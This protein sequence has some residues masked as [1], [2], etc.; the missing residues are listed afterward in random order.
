MTECALQSSTACLPITALASIQVDRKVLLFAGQGQYLQIYDVNSTQISSTPIF[1]A[2]PV[3]GIRVLTPEACRNSRYFLLIAIWGGRS[4]RIVRIKLEGYIADFRHQLSSPELS[5]QQT[6]PDWILDTAYNDNSVFVLTAHNQLQKFPIFFG[7]TEHV[8]EG[9]SISVINGPKSFLYSGCLTIAGPDLMIVAS[10]TVFGEIL[11]W[12]CQR[13]EGEE[14]WKPSPSH[15]FM[16]HKGSVF[17]VSI[18]DVLDLAGIRKRLLASCSDDRTI[19]LWDISDCDQDERETSHAINSIETGFGAISEAGQAHIACVWGHASRIW[20]VEFVPQGMR[21]RDQPVSLLSRGED[22]ACQLWDIDLPV[23]KDADNGI[24]VSIKPKAS[25]RIH[26]GKN[27]WSMCTLKDEQGMLVHTGGADGQMISRRFE[28]P[29]VTNRRPLTIVVPFNKITESSKSLK[30]YTLLSQSEC[31]ATTDQGN[32]YRLSLIEGKLDWEKVH[33]DLPN[34]GVTISWLEDLSLTLL[35]HQKGGLFALMDSQ[36]SL[37][38]VSCNLNDP[39]SWMQAAGKHSAGS[40]SPRICVVAVSS[41]KEAVIL[42]MNTVEDSVQARQ[43]ALRLPDTFTITAC[44][45]DQSSGVLLL[46]SRAGALAIYS[47]F[48]PELS[49]AQ[50]AYCVRH[51]HATDS[52][53][54]I[55][56]LP[57]EFG[58][59]NDTGSI[60]VLTTGRDGSYAIHRLKWS[61]PD[62]NEPLVSVVHLSSPPFGPNVEGAYLVSSSSNEDHLDLILYGFRS[63]CFIVWNETQQFEVVSVEC[64]GAHRSWCYKDSYEPSADNRSKSFIWTKAGQFN[65]HNSNGSSHKV[66]RGGG[67][68]REI[69]AVARSSIP[70]TGTDGRR[71]GRVLV[72]T[73][74][75][76]TN[77]LLFAIPTKKE[78]AN[79]DRSSGLQPCKD[80]EFEAVATL[81]RH[82]TG[83]QHLQFAPSGEYLFS[84]AGCEEFYAWKLTFDVPC[85]GIGTVLW[86]TMPTDE[87]DSDARIMSFDLQDGNESGYIVA[88]ACSSGKIKVVRYVPG[89]TRDKGVFELV[90]VINY[91]SFCLMQAFFLSPT[92]IL[93]RKQVQD[94]TRILS[95][96]TNGHLNVEVFDGHSRIDMSAPVSTSETQLPVEVHNVHQ[97]S[98]LAM[99]IMHLSPSTHL[100]ATGGDDNAL[101]ITI[102][103]CPESGTGRNRIRLRTILIPNAHA[104][105][106]TA[107]KIIK[108]E[109]GAVETSALLVTVSNDQRFKIWRVSL[110]RENTLGRSDQELGSD[111]LFEAV[112][113]KLVGSVWTGVADVSGVEVVDEADASGCG[114]RILVVGVGME[115]M[116]ITWNGEETT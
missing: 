88:M 84:S 92:S 21:S 55:T 38:S 49:T 5:K 23:N 27:A 76:D 91:G 42:W 30:I 36:D 50:E 16:G 77:I 34:G 109:V 52:V 18:S 64:G 108:F 54:S 12:T 74:A 100:I 78:S 62:H 95:A 41:N 15:N 48:T 58:I 7:I 8:A 59:S 40:R 24:S 11:V 87:E 106:L 107:L 47:N 69:K 71:P 112:Q 79:W 101:G 51:V 96:G 98:I 65:W 2:Q 44:C 10:G 57:A 93:P 14:Q 25:D 73:G 110:D 56:V 17:G 28:T 4:L 45:Y 20:D 6:C 33:A 29:D 105:A 9:G 3:L 67:H 81:Q 75:E 66:I 72:A 82:T 26:N 90:R 113:V 60:N 32:L 22:G 13:T 43:T 31:L 89:A 46:G 104:G 99:D 70:Y 1:E 85:V 83:L 19:R 63:S 114:N 37:V 39:I 94:Q 111:R 102:F 35:A 86:D 68:G 116:S 61:F 80:T 53:T 97:S 115:L 103:T